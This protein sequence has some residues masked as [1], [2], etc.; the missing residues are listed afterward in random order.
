MFDGVSDGEIRQSTVGL[1]NQ[2]FLKAFVNICLVHEMKNVVGGV[3]SQTLIRQDT[4]V[5]GRV[6]STGSLGSLFIPTLDAVGVAGLS[7]QDRAARC[8]VDTILIS[9]LLGRVGTRHAG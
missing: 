7:S 5:I 6:G 2:G 9:L 4:W 1:V 3:H 8:A